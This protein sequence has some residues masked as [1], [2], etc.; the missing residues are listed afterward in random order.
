MTLTD[1]QHAQHTENIAYL[2]KLSELLEPATAG[3]ILSVAQDYRDLLANTD[4]LVAALSQCLRYIL[5]DL[6]GWED[7]N[8][9]NEVADARAILDKVKS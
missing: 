1:K 8:E 2:V 6:P 9:R 3:H 4:E 5:D 7:P